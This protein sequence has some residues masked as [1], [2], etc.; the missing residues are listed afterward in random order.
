MST[1]AIVD[2]AEDLVLDP[3]PDFFY[4]IVNGEVRELIM[5]AYEVSVG[6]RLF[7]RVANFADQKAIGRAFT[8]ILFRLRPGQPQRRPDVAFVSFQRWEKDRRVPRSNAWPVVPDLAVEVISPS[9][10]G[11]EIQEKMT[12]YFEAGV[13][14]IWLVW[15]NSEQVQVFTSMT[16]VRII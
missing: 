3:E 6:N 16:D 15:P 12:E 13:R 7:Q 2:E 11:I 8:E 9:E 14:L 1:A 10:F 5:S 4:E